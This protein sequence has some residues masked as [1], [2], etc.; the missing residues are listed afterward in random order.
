MN[1]D[2]ISRKV[3]KDSLKEYFSD[4][5]LDSVS[6]KVSFNMIL[7]KIDEIPTPT[8]MVDC[9]HCDGYEA[10]YSAGLRDAE[11]GKNERT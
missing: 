3:L 7:M 6:A 10:G 9:K 8:T 1:N 5:I 11:R 2:L 4:G